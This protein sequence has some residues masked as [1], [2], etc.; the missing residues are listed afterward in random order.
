MMNDDFGSFGNS[1]SDDLF[2]DSFGNDSFGDDSFG[3]D[4]F[5][6]PVEDSAFSSNGQ[7][8]FSD[9]FENMQNQTQFQ[10]NVN[11]DGEG[12]KKQAIIAIVVG[13]VGVI[14]VLL[15]AGAVNNKKQHTVDE[16]QQVQQVQEVQDSNSNV[17]NIMNNSEQANSNTASNSNET[18]VVLNSVDDGDKWIEITNSEAVTF[19]EEYSENVFTI[20]SIKHLARTVDT[21]N[22]LVVKTK[23]QGSLSGL[24][25]TYEI[26]I[27]YDK[28]VQLAVGDS[29]T[30]KVQLGTY[31]GKT[32]VG[33][34]QY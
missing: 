30:V 10:D 8:A 19:N 23:L 22:N 9:S 4:S 11:T 7:N 3:N 28:G 31:N 2:G 34:I 27:P 17:D 26:D 1:T 32:V 5:G 16:Q 33:E 24:P 25:G 12:I 29:F 6:E 18:T 14:A 20:T 13:V 15:I 21:N